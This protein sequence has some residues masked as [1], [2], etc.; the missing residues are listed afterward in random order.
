MH[1]SIY[2]DMEY[3]KLPKLEDD[4][5]DVAGEPREEEGDADQQNH[6]VR[7]LSTPL[8][9]G[10]PTLRRYYSM[11]IFLPNQ[12]PPTFDLKAWGQTVRTHRGTVAEPD[13]NRQV[14]S[15]H[16]EDGEH[17][18]QDYPH[19]AVYFPAKIKALYYTISR[20]PCVLMLASKFPACCPCR[21]RSAL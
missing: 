4:V 17:E 3:Q 11:N 8:R 9:L 18:L 6:H 20:F 12:F 5:E 13:V 10:V 21:G 19:Q 7:P 1:S 14:E 2:I 16:D 15:D